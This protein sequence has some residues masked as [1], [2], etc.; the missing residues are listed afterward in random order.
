MLESTSSDK[1]VRFCVSLPPFVDV[2]A[3]CFLGL[4][5]LFAGTAGLVSVAADSV[6]ILVAVSV[7]VSFVVVVP[8]AVSV[9]A[10]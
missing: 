7:A 4:P 3:F 10:V 1:R 6:A 2:A 8:V 9:V 5:T